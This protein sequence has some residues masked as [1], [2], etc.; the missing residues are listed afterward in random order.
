[1]LLSKI[2]LYEEPSVPEINFDSLANFLQDFFRVPVIK[3]KNIF[4]QKGLDVAHDV[5]RTRVYNYRQEFQI[6]DP[7]TEEV[8]FEFESFVN[9]AKTENIVLYDGFELQKILTGLIGNDESKS[10]ILHLVLTNKL[11]CT[12]DNS[13]YRYHGRALIGSNPA[14]IST[15]GII[16]APAKPREYYMDLMKNYGIGLNIDSIKEK[17]KGTYLEYHD[18]RLDKIVQGYALQAIFYYI[19]GESFCDLLDCRLN[20]A[21]WQSDLLYSQLEFGRLCAKHEKA[22]K[23]WLTLNYSKKMALL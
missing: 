10:D 13:D 7:T 21:H 16:E 9:S 6:H 17:Y 1:M 14:I 22:I 11:T 8:Q 19:F 2:F 5:A 4:H 15:T 18:S 3:R 12:F 23:D 20:N